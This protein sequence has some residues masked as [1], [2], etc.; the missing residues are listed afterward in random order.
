MTSRRHRVKA[1]AVLLAM[2]IV[3]AACGGGGDA[4]QTG[5]VD[6]A[7]TVVGAIPTTPPISGS[8]ADPLA[9]APASGPGLPAANPWEVTVLHVNDDVQVIQAFDGPNGNPIKLHDVNDIDNVELEYPLNATTHFGNRLALLVEEIDQ[10]GNWAKVRVPVRPNGTT[11]W[12]QTAFFTQEKHDYHIKVS[13]SDNSVKV[14]KGEDLIVEQVAVLGKPSAPTPLLRSYID[15]KI[16]GDQ[17][18]PAYGKWILSIAGFS[19]SLGAFNGG[20]PKLALHGTNQPELMGQFVS[21]GCIRVPDEV[22]DLI[23][24]TVPVGTIV[25]IVA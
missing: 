11:A 2:A 10:S 12:V 17:L 9:T 7:A 19:E 20:L 16:P 8:T 3:A 22:I 18:S 24:N 13:L 6:G 25:E 15:E 4:E 1:L 14:F 5:S 21:N 23:A